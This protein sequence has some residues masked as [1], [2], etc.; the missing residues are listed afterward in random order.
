MPPA[1]GDI[2]HNRYH[3][4][5]PLPA[6]GGMSAVYRAVDTR[7]HVPC[8]VKEMAPYLH[9][10]ERALAQLREQFFQEAK[11]LAELHHPNMPRVIDH[12]EYES[13]VYLVM[14]FVEGERLDELIAKDKTLSLDTILLWAQEL[15][16]ALNYCHAQRVIHRDVKPQNVIITPQGKAMLVDF[17]LVKVLDLDDRRT[18]T[19]M[20]GLGTPEYAPPEQYD[21]ETG[22]TDARTDVYSLG[23]TLY[24]ALTGTPP[25]TATQRI[26]NPSLLKSVRHHQKA[27]SP[28]VDEAISK[29]MS[30]Q[31]DQR[32]MTMTQMAAAILQQS[33]ATPSDTPLLLRMVRPLN[34]SMQTVR[35]SIAGMRNA[36]RRRRWAGVGAGG[37]VATVAILFFA[38]RTDL[39]ATDSPTATSTV[40]LSP[41]GTHTPSPTP[42]STV[43]PTP[44]GTPTLAPTNTPIPTLTFTPTSTPT[45]TP[46][47]TPTPTP[48]GTL[49]PTLTPTPT[50][51]LTPRPTWTH[52]PTPTPTNTPVPQ[53]PG[54][55]PTRTNTPTPTP[56]PT[57]THTP[58]NTPTNTPEHTPTTRPI[59]PPPTPTDTPTPTIQL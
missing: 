29:A 33:A 4:E 19:V 34:N 18:R 32:F 2:I 14:D 11:V 52:T 27:I 21:A 9:I 6:Q 59:G 36:P 10:D 44:T 12:F 16:D 45:S 31:P 37:A 35:L 25:P 38:V 49:T 58:T 39:F 24:H 17:G 22:S 26:V 54:P 48:T 42:T 50:L 40:F 57:H 28:H 43:R 41:T 46:T 20:R 53:G 8:A 23:A 13:N 3:I 47:D 51:T 7:L 1:P 5:Y 56:T 55:S 15:I 30:L